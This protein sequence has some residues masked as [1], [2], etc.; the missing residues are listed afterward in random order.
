MKALSI[1]QPWAWLIVT[2]KKDIENR[3]W[4]TKDRGSFLIHASKKFDSMGYNWVV[5]EMGLKMPPPR[6]LNFG[7]IV[8]MAEITDCVTDYNNP[9][10]FGPYGFILENAMTLPFFPLPGKLGFFDVDR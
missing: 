10:F 2:G 4:F 7:G 3:T 6:E 5:S 1:R 8:G 9:W